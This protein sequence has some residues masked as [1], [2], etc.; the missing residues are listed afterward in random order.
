ME[1]GIA[2]VDRVLFV[3][4]KVTI[5]NSKVEDGKGPDVCLECIPGRAIAVNLRRNVGEAAAPCRRPSR[6]RFTRQIEIDKHGVS[7]G[8]DDYVVALYVRMVDT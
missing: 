5:Q 8:I 2:S 4:G 3:K 7:V 1:E 6:G